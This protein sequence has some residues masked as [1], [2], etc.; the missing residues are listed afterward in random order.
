MRP[1]DMFE[2]PQTDLFSEYRNFLTGMELCMS[3]LRARLS[4]RP[5]RLVIELPESEITDDLPAQFVA[6]LHRYCDHRLRY[7]TTER[8]ALRIGGLP[9]SGSASRWRRPAWP[10]PGGRTRART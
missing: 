7:T 1:A 6:T 2:M 5:V 4:R 10:S 3:E 8:R 9:R